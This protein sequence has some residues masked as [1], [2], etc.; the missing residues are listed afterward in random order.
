MFGFFAKIAFALNNPIASS[1][2]NVVITIAVIAAD[3]VA[4][5]IKDPEHIAIIDR[6]ISHVMNIWQRS[7]CTHEM[8][9]RSSLGNHFTNWIDDIPSNL[10][11]ILVLNNID[12]Q[13]CDVSI[14]CQ[15]KPL[16][17]FGRKVCRFIIRL[18]VNL[19]DLKRTGMYSSRNLQFELNS[20]I[21]R[22]FKITIPL[23]LL[24]NVSN[25]HVILK[26]IDFIKTGIKH[27]ERERLC[28]AALCYC[29]LS[30]RAHHRM[31]WVIRHNR[32]L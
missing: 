18:S 26:S 13:R 21:I 2:L 10:L 5:A 11:T 28:H 1:I 25:R 8:F 22:W 30:A 9:I 15:L 32:P 14:S 24:I 12:F 6:Q 20:N 7:A 23:K 29:F 3:A 16:K 27:I 4:V 19:C 17:A 31:D